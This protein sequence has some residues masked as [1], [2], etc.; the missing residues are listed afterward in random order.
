MVQP[1]LAPGVIVTEDDRTGSVPG[2]STSTG[3]IVGDFR[4]GPADKVT[5]VSSENDL[6]AKFAAP[7]RTNAVDFLSAAS[8]LQYSQDLKVVRTVKNALNATN[9]AS[10]VTVKNSEDYDAQTLVYSDVGGFVAKYPGALGNSLKVSVFSFTA[11]AAT[12]ASNFN[13]W[14]YASSFDTP[15]GTT[16]TAASLGALNDE[17][18][19]AVID[20]GGLFTGTP[21]AVLETFPYLSQADGAKND[22]GT[23]SFYKDV[24]NLRSKY[25]W[26]ADHDTSTLPQ[27]G[28]A[29]ATGVDYIGLESTGV[30][31]YSLAGGTDSEAIGAAE[32]TNGL[33][34]F[35]RSSGADVSIL[36]GPNLTG[37]TATTVANAYI[38]VAATRADLFLILSPRAEDID[39]TTQNEFAATLS[40]DKHYELTSGRVKAYDKYNDQY[41]NIPD[42]GKVGGAMALADRNFGPFFS[43]AGQKRGQLFGVTE[44]YYN[45]NDTDRGNLYKNGINPIVT[46]P[47]KGTFILGDRT[48]IGR[49]SIFRQIHAVRLLILLR[50]SLKIAG[51]SVL[52]QF[53]DEFT[54]N[55]F[56]NLIEPLL[57][58]IQGRRGLTDYR[59]ICDSSNNTPDVVDAQE[60]VADIYVKIPN[61]INFVR[62]NLI[63]TR[64]GVNLDVTEGVQV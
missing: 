23:N 40:A 55:E 10:T 30:V 47:G 5:S 41:V 20:E 28:V 49:P 24:I 6:V 57:R 19:I 51:E 22:D 37:P 9:G 12:T 32:Y 35:N 46:V 21:G 39:E 29:P 26:F 2:V 61:S 7:S 31:E 59:I 50:K 62:I 54:Q 18:H 14:T 8:F 33:D 16:A 27:A 1:L 36:I 42:S 63:A 64:S 11:D 43:P 15:V 4:W 44:L 48:R 34:Y 52:F 53:N 58:Q 60:F 56:V 3:A 38:T 17:I 13:A 45:P 25:V